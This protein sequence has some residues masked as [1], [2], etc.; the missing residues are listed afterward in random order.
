[1]DK[2]S[3]RRFGGAGS[4]S[5][6]TTLADT[7]A[8]FVFRLNDW[9]VMGDGGV[10]V[11]L[12]DE[13]PLAVKDC[14]PNGETGGDLIGRSEI[15]EG[16]TKGN[17]SRIESARVDAAD[18]TEDPETLLISRPCASSACLCWSCNTSRP[19]DGLTNRPIVVLNDLPVPGDLSPRLTR[20]ALAISMMDPACVLKLA[21]R[22]RVSQ[23]TEGISSA[24]GARVGCADWRGSWEARNVKAVGAGE[25]PYVVCVDIFSSAKGSAS[26]SG[27]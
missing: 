1:M 11:L 19:V 12:S 21:G 26:S 23:G 25:R 3:N 17:D 10:K 20:V 8:V 9:C 15:G 22:L 27:V 6:S 2:P 18:K 16:G 5:R 24:S 14:L 4:E 7:P 13:A